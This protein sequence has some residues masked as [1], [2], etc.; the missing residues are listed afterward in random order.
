MKRLF[1]V[2]VVISLL[3]YTVPCGFVVPPWMSF[4]LVSHVCPEI[5][6]PIPGHQAYP[7]GNACTCTFD[8]SLI[9]GVKYGRNS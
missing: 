5:P 7:S 3:S 4:G 9:I 2:L 6:P 8:S 1:V